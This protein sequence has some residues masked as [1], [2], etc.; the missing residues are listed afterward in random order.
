V[1]EEEEAT[2]GDICIG[3]GVNEVPEG[4]RFD[5]IRGLGGCE[6]NVSATEGPG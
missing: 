3:G 6:G 4:G 1:V 2:V 5:G